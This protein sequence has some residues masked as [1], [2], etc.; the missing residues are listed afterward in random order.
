MRWLVVAAMLALAVVAAAAGPWL[1]HHGIQLE[2]AWPLGIAGVLALANAGYLAMLRAA[3]N[4]PHLAA[5]AHRGLWLQI[6][7]DLAVLTAVVHFLGSVH[8]VAPLMYLF[9][10]VLV[11]IFFSSARESGR[12]GDRHGH[13]R[14]VRRSGG[15]RRSSGP[16]DVAPRPARGRGPGVRGALGLDRP[17]GL[18]GA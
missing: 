11:C 17:C 13:V 4:S 18:G 6:L 7:V 16:I 2:A 8:S 12:H 5:A 3:R 15:F 9:H 10:I 1:S 14:V